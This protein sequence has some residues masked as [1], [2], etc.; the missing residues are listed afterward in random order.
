MRIRWLEDS[1]LLNGHL[2][3]SRVKLSAATRKRLHQQSMERRHLTLLKRTARG[4]ATSQR[5]AIQLRAVNGKL[6]R[7]VWDYN[8]QRA[9]PA[10]EEVTLDMVREPDNPFYNLL[11]VRDN[12]PYTVRKSAVFAHELVQRAEE[13]KRALHLEMVAL[14]SHFQSCKF[15]LHQALEQAEMRGVKS[16]LLTAC[17][18]NEMLQLHLSNVARRQFQLDLVFDQTVLH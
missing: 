12:V 16:Y 2:E 1:T 3:R 9:V 18:E 14:M 13:E 4:H 7:L 10:G 6:V 8:T 15:I 5:L 11:E 17:L